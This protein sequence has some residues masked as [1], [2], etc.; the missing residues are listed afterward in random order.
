MI[1][2]MNCPTCGA[3]LDVADTSCPKCG[4]LRSV[5]STSPIDRIADS[6]AEAAHDVVRAVPSVPK[7][8]DEV[9]AAGREVLRTARSSGKGAGTTAKNLT[10]PEP[11]PR[12]PRTVRSDVDRRSRER[13]VASTGTSRA[14]TRARVRADPAR[15]G[16]HPSQATE[17]RAREDE[18]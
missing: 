15:A 5:A 17:R 14:R 1:A 7:V 13:T 3:P 10:S 12:V 8:G 11:F 6:A 18:T 9:A 16:Q 4:S 2:A